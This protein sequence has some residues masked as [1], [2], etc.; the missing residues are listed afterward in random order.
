[1][2]NSIAKMI[3]SRMVQCLSPDEIPATPRD[4]RDLLSSPPPG[5]KDWAN[6]EAFT[7]M[8]SVRAPQ[9]LPGGAKIEQKYLCAS[10]S[11]ACRVSSFAVRISLQRSIARCLNSHKPEQEQKRALRELDEKLAQHTLRLIKRLKGFY[12]KMAQT[13]VGANMFPIPYEQAFA[14]LL[15]N[16]PAAP[17]EV[18]RVIVESELGCP[19]A[20]IFESFD[21]TPLG[22][23]SIG[24]AHRATLLDGSS[25]VVKVQ[26]PEAERFFFSDMK[27]GNAL[28]VFLFS[29][30]LTE[31]EKKF[32]DEATAQAAKSYLKEFDYMAEAESLERCA[33]TTNPRFGH[34]VQVP[35]PIWYVP[36]NGQ[37]RQPL[38]TKKVLTMELL[39]GESV[40]RKV[41]RH[42][43]Q[44]AAERGMSLNE[45][46]EQLANEG[47]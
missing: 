4:V 35:K 1:M 47:E 24:Q 3:A 12:V 14:D 7:L 11:R 43:E 15:D 37:K 10:L 22:A 2:M 8:P 31:E 44:L 9:K 41:D 40:K 28:Q 39:P 17:I 18:V 16:C 21:P 13:L 29:Q 6:K 33:M 45:L 32:I 42:M 27:I 36:G 25:V 19:M 34:Q 23:A 20:H 30:N 38:C 46:K 26:Y 5:M